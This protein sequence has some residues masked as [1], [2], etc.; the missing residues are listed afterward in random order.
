MLKDLNLMDATIFRQPHK[1][2]VA[3][4]K[5]VVLA[6]I[7]QSNTSSTRN[8]EVVHDSGTADVVATQIVSKQSMNARVHAKNQPAKMHAKCQRLRDHAMDT[9]PNTTMIPIEISVHH[10]FM[11]VAWAILTD[12]KQQKSAR[13]NAL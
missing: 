9:T 12:L 5:M 3:S 1:R 10:L 4:V 2:H 13:N 8:M 11:V 7:T 6:V